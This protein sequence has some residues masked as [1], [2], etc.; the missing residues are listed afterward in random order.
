ML[1]DGP[2]REVIAPT[3]EESEVKEEI[4]VVK[5]ETVDRVKEPSIQL[6]EVA[7]EVRESDRE[8]DVFVQMKE[9]VT[10][11]GEVSTHQEVRKTRLQDQELPTEIKE[12]VTYPKEE[13]I[14]T[15][16]NEDSMKEKPTQED[17]RGVSEP[18][19]STWIVVGEKRRKNRSQSTSDSDHIKKNKS[20]QVKAEE[21]SRRQTQV[22]PKLNY[23][24]AIQKSLPLKPAT[25]PPIQAPVVKTGTQ[26][27]S[28]PDTTNVVLPD[29]TTPLPK[30]PS[31][32]PPDTA[33]GPS[34]TPSEPSPHTSS[35]P[36]PLN[37]YP[38][39]DILP[40]TL[41]SS[42]FSIDYTPNTLGLNHAN[43][44]RDSIDYS[45]GYDGYYGYGPIS[46]SLHDEW[47]PKTHYGQW[48]ERE[49]G[50]EREPWLDLSSFPE[51]DHVQYGPNST[52]SSEELQVRV[53]GE[54]DE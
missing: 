44:F 13:D 25:S 45:L 31:E 2:G 37:S 9:T 8:K 33:N 54:N 35:E 36:I 21:A 52:Y 14:K 15:E 53:S 46:N 19:D 42:S 47:W 39:P 27:K 41:P 4:Q 11:S 6:N 28:L 17:L 12:K 22:A 51:E 23:K 29:M 10:S 49:M 48:R 16:S 18:S 3:K 34:H 32:P 26:E 24:Q 50:L 30:I 40:S 7:E 38:I 1:R 20:R 43:G 5:K